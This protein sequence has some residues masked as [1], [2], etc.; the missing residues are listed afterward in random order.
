VERTP[1]CRRLKNR[2]LFV[3]WQEDPD[4][5]DTFDGFYWC[6]H[7]MNC[8][9]PDGELALPESCRPGRGCFES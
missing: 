8:L 9:G 6:S 1:P 4:V 5:P 7:T 2:R 3:E